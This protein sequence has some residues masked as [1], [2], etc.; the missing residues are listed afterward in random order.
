MWQDRAACKG[1]DSAVFLVRI[2]RY[3][4]EA[5]AFCRRCPVRPECL[6]H[7]LAYKGRALKGVWGGTLEQD[8]RPENRER[9]RRYA[10]DGRPEWQAKAAAKTGRPRQPDGSVGRYRDG[11]RCGA[12]VD[13][14]RAH[15]R[16]IQQLRRDRKREAA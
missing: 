13:R 4:T 8:R 3:P 15:W 7:C 6:E 1:A 10:R 2:G 12:C 5:L 11:C 14:M 16:Y 9:A